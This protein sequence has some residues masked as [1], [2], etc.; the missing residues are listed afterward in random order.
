MTARLLLSIG[1]TRDLQTHHPRIRPDAK[2]G[3]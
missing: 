1:R 2:E 3:D